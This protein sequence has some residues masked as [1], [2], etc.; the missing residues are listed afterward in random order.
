MYDGALIDNC[1]FAPKSMADNVTQTVLELKEQ[2]IDPLD[3]IPVTERYQNEEPDV[4]PEL[5]RKVDDELEKQSLEDTMMSNRP[6][7]LKPKTVEVA[8]GTEDF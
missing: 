1:F 8:I 4:E 3:L 6:L 2:G 5:P 7:L